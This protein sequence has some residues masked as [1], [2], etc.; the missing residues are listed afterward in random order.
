MVA[1][2]PTTPPESPSDPLSRGERAGERLASDT[3]APEAPAALDAPLPTSALLAATPNSSTSEI[4][5]PTSQI[6]SPPSPTSDIAPPTSDISPDHL[7]TLLLTNHLNV[8]ATAA[9]A[10]VPLHQ[11]LDLL[12]TEQSQRRLATYQQFQLAQVNTRILATTADSRINAI[13]QLEELNKSSTNP[14]EQRRACNLILRYSTPLPPTWV[15][16]R[17]AAAA[18]KPLEP[19]PRVGPSSNLLPAEARGVGSLDSQVPAPVPGSTPTPTSHIQNPTSSTP[20]LLHSSTSAPIPDPLPHFPNPQSLLLHLERN[21]IRQRPTNKKGR[22][23]AALSLHRYLAPG[24]TINTTEVPTD[25]VEFAQ[26]LD[27]I[28]D[29]HLIAEIVQVQRRTTH[30]DKLSHIERMYLIRYRQ[31]QVRAHVT[32]KRD[33]EHAPWRITDISTEINNSS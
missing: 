23:A 14:I 11:V 31:L 1:D 27:P 2:A 24:A 8:E 29:S 19:A 3:R 6:S 18:L 9:Q 30:T 21:F 10:Q 26:Y 28:S 16:R 25:P 22:L 4:P 5:N 20:P 7:F 32:L 12:A 15:P 33:D 17:S 13:K